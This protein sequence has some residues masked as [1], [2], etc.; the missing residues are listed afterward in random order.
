MSQG[1]VT[2]AL[3]ASNDE[4]LEQL[5][6]TLQASK[7]QFYL[8]FLHCNCSDDGFQQQVLGRL[9]ELCAFEVRPLLLEKSVEALYNRIHQELERECPFAL[10]VFGLESVRNLDQLLTATNYVREEYRKNC[11]FPLMLWVN[12][13]VLKKL[14]RLVPDFE[15]WAIRTVIQV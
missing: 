5:A 3:N 13:E 2:E 12:D 15:N 14:I 10:I 4:A 9:K 6:W 7:R 11:S 8:I 1:Q